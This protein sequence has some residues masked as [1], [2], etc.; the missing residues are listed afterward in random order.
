MVQEDAAVKARGEVHL[1][2]EAALVNEVRPLGQVGQARLVAVP[3]RQ[4]YM[5]TKMAVASST[6][7]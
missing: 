6:V 5:T 3:R 7:T 2:G 4:T 1:K